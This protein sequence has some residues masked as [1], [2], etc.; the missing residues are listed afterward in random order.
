MYLYT[1]LIA[2]LQMGRIDENQEVIAQIQLAIDA[3]D[4]SRSPDN[5]LQDD[6]LP[7][8]EE[9]NHAQR[10]SCSWCLG[11][12]GQLTT[13]KQLETDFVQTG[14]S[15][16]LHNNFNMNLKEFLITNTT[17]NSIAADSTIKVSSNCSSTSGHSLAFM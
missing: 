9:G 7:T 17:S 5:V 6:E 10:D 15:S 16:S 14:I 11:A 1:D 8:Q 13:A 4:K 12:P 2:M 3:Y